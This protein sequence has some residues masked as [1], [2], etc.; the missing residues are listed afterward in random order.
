MIIKLELLYGMLGMHVADF[1]ISLSEE[2]AEKLFKKFVKEL[3]EEQKKRETAK[4]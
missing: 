2:R 3:Q 1:Q 4:D